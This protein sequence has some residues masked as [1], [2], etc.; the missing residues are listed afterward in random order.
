MARTAKRSRKGDGGFWSGAPSPRPSPARGEG[1]RRS[2]FLTARLP[3]LR[4]P[5]P[6][7]GRV[8]ERG[9]RTTSVRHPPAT[10]PPNPTRAN[11]KNPTGV[12]R[13]VQTSVL[14]Q[15]NDSRGV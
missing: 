11:P 15:G 10:A 13:T 1:G 14:Y 2:P 4:S 12:T 9:R 6:L 3:E 7:R 5:P 8:K